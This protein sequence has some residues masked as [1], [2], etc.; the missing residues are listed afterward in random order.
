MNALTPIAGVVLAGG[1]SSRMGGGHKAAVYLDGS[2]LLERV[3]ERFAPQVDRLLVNGNGAVVLPP[4]VKGSL[5]ADTVGNFP[6]P[7]AGLVSA[8]E[9]L[10]RENTAV[11]AVALVPCDGPFLPRNLVARLAAAMA[12]EQTVV[13]C[14]RYRGEIQPTFSLWR[15]SVAAAAAAELRDRRRGGFKGLLGRLPASFVDWPDA[16]V[17]PFFNV[18]EPADL[19]R[20]RRLLAAPSQAGMVD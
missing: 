18:N 7:L 15:R 5:I 17:D 8:F 20:A 19:D 11:E 14:T 1:R 4:G 9:Y 16:P 2:T 12:N 6:G 3:I 10:E 13:A